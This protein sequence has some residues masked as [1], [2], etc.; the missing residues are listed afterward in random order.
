MMPLLSD[1]PDAIANTFK[2]AERCNVEIELGNIQ[3]PHFEVPAGYDGNDYLPEWCEQG[4]I[5]VLARTSAEVRRN[6]RTSGL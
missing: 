2:I 6:S 4:F 3:L 1:M 5:N